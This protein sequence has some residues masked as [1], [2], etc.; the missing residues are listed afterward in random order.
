MIPHSNVGKFLNL[1]DP[2]QELCPLRIEFPADGEVEA[3]F[4]FF[5]DPLARLVQGMKVVEGPFELEVAA[6]EQ[7]HGVTSP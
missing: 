6:V 2:E 5:R 7:T 3:I 4:A 1:D